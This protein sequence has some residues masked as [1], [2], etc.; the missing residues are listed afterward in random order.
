MLRFFKSYKPDEDNE[1]QFAFKVVYQSVMQQFADITKE[2]SKVSQLL[3]TQTKLLTLVESK[4]RENNY[5]KTVEGNDLFQDQ[6]MAEW[7]H[8]NA[9]RAR[10][11]IERYKNELEEFKKN[12]AARSSTLMMKLTEWTLF[13]EWLR[14]NE[15]MKFIIDNIDLTIDTTLKKIRLKIWNLLIEKATTENWTAPIIFL[16]LKKE[17]LESIVTTGGR[18]SKHKVK[19]F[20]SLQKSKTRRIKHYKS[21]RKITYLMLNVNKN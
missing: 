10:E 12:T 1:K 7:E 9:V 14:H 5:R 8:P 3:E 20:N 18:R 6:R 17:K 4:I 15:T 2:N 21:K 16:K 19:K 13:T 11:D